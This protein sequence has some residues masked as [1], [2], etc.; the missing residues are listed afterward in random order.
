MR[1]FNIVGCINLIKCRHVT[2]IQ[3]K[4]KKYYESN[5]KQ[6]TTI[7][8]VKLTAEQATLKSYFTEY[9]LVPL[10]KAIFIVYQGFA[11]DLPCDDA[12][13]RDFQYG[14]VLPCDFHYGKVFSQDF[15]FIKVSPETFNMARFHPRFCIMERF[16]PGLAQRKGSPQDMHNS[17]VTT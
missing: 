1:Y 17:E 2:Q 10:K 12:S 5:T 11:R 9:I 16:A 15:E 3:S 6:S 13:P 8:W 7:Q 4:G 14:K